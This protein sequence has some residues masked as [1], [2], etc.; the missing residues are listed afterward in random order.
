M[1]TTLLFILAVAV[2]FVTVAFSV[3]IQPRWAISLLQKIY[4]DVLFKIK[5]KKKIIAL[6][7]DDG[8]TATLTPQILDLLEQHNCKCTFFLIGSQI[9]KDGNEKLLERMRKEG[10]ELG[11]HTWEDVASRKLPIDELEKQIKRVD[12]LLFPNTQDVSKVFRPGHGRFTKEMVETAK[13]LGYRTVLGSVYPFDP[14]FKNVTINST[15]VEKRVHPGA[16]IILHD[17]ATR[18]HT[19]PTLQRVLPKLKEMG[20][21]V[22]TVTELLKHEN[23]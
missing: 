19:I 23:T 22:T 14:Q 20:Y 8:P 18:T 13:S 16:I 17:G 6:T 3:Y 11:N 2:L 1:V 12:K 4:P 7:I 5:T 9:I 10:H 15:F 21:E